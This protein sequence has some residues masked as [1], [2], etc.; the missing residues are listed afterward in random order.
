MHY[1]KVFVCLLFFNTLVGIEGVG[2]NVL[3]SEAELTRLKEQAIYYLSKKQPERAY[4]TLKPAELV[5]AGDAQ[6]NYLLGMAAIDSGHP[7]D[8]SWAFERVVAVMPHHAGARMDMARAFFQLKD[9]PRAEKEFQLLQ[10]MNPPE[11]AQKAIAFYLAEI[12]RLSD[13]HPKWILSGSAFTTVGYSSNATGAPSESNYIA[14]FAE[15]FSMSE[16]TVRRLYDVTDGEFEASDNFVEAGISGSAT[17]KLPGPWSFYIAPTISRKN[18]FDETDYTTTSWSARLGT[19]WR[20]GRS[21]LNIYAQRSD[22]SQEN[23]SGV[24]VS[25]LMAD[26]GFLLSNRSRVGGQVSKSDNTFDGS[27][28]NDS[29][30]TNL[31]FYA[32]YIFGQYRPFVLQTQ[33]TKTDDKAVNGRTDGDKDALGIAVMGQFIFNQEHI[34]F[35][36]VNR[37]ASEYDLKR[38]LY[39]TPRDETQMIYGLGYLW[40]LNKQ[41]GIKAQVSRTETSSNISLYDMDKQDASV[42]LN[43]NF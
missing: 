3:G 8:A 22:S 25:M 26:Y 13:R 10:A 9:Y 5:Y 24:A 4:E 7:E 11:S 18:W 34:F 43:Y 42:R 19:R 38:S 16:D 17:Y 31:T 36:N 27:S 39:D 29:E 40:Q 2:A 6:Y 15:M 1:F 20:Q 33:L 37:L 28:T 14:A 21:D 35:A 12:D 30:T 32:S 41:L 23:D